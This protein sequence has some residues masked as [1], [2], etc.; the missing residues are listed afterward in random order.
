MAG[1]SGRPSDDR[2]AARPDRLASRPSQRAMTPTAAV[3][4]QEPAPF[5]ADPFATPASPT[6]A[7][8]ADRPGRSA[9]ADGGV[10]MESSTE[11]EGTGQPGSQQ[12][13]GVQ[14]PQLTIQ[15]LAPKEIQVGK[16]A[17]FRVTVRNTG[18]FPPAKSRSA[19]WCPR[20]RGCWAPRRA[21]KR[22]TRGEIDL[23]AGNDP[24]RRGSERGNAIDAHGRGR[25]RQRG[26]GPFRGRRLGPH[27]GHPAATGRRRRR[28]PA[29]VLIGEQVTLT[30]TV[31]NPGTGM[32]TGVVLEERIPPG[33]QHPAG[34]ELEYEVGDLKP[35]ES[36]KLDLPLVANRPGPATNLLTA[37]GDGNLRAEDKREPGSDCPAVGRGR[38]RAE[39]ALPGAPGHVPV[40]G[41][42]SG[43]GGRPSRSKL[44]ANLPAGLKFVSANNAGY[45]EEV[46][47]DRPLAAGGIAGQRDRQRRAGDDAG[48]SRPASDRLRGTAQ[49]GLAVEKEQPVLIEGI[50]GDLRSRWP[51][52]ST[53]SRL[54]AK[55]P[56]KCAWC[57]QGSK[58][59]ANVRLSV[60]LPPEVKPVSAEGPT[61]HAMDGSRV[62]FDGLARLAPKA[63]ATYRVRVK[64]LRPGD[65]AH[66]L[67]TE[68]RRHADPGH[69]GREHA[70]V[71]GRI[72]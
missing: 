62:V 14:T 60:D 10:A 63:D 70:G 68:D 6:R 33:L 39:A 5:R 46:D 49:K 19:T 32:A 9:S 23:D 40:V 65:F 58:A 13:E 43:H 27:D 2:Y 44:V 31:S 42:Q 8:K 18:Q 26:H 28:R 45:Y 37:R 66:P 57:N 51:T 54:A 25:D 67:P 21:A 55:R 11:G 15:K 1:D 50:A 4:T 56:T 30:I 53:R 29:K 47:P 61:R 69:Q 59:A 12:L 38:G 41:H 22:G 72:G 7:V 71:R 17:K 52:R 35:G 34:T 3:E 64:A 20:A 16:P 48:R 24:A 36:R